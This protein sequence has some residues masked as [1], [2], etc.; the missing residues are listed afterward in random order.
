MLLPL[1]ALAL[2]LSVARRK[3]VSA[4][5]RGQQVVLVTH[6]PLCIHSNGSIHITM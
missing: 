2:M 5:K 1:L 3:S 4:S 6:L